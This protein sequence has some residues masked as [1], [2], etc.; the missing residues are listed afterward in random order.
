MII[1][2]PAG[3][4]QNRP[5]FISMHGMNQT[6][7]DQKNQTQFESVAQANNFVLFFH[8]QSVLI[9]T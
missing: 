5:L 3:I 4:E 9:G 7:Q 2:A 1:Y 8:S 6:M